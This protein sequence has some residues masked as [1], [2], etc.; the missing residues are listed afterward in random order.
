MG[1]DGT[2]FLELGIE[3]GEIYNGIGKK[4]LKRGMGL[5]RFLKREM[6]WDER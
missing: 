5:D 3:W 2:R 1:R 4:F 6:G